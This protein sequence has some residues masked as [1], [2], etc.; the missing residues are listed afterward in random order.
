M[1]IKKVRVGV[2]GA[3]PH[4]GWAPRSHL[5][6]LGDSADCELTAVCT[7]KQESAEESKRTFGARLAFHDY[8][9]MIAHPDIDAV[10]VVLR[11]PSHYEPTMAALEAGKH[12]YTEW[13]LG[14]TTAQARE[15][16]DKARAKGVMNAVGLQA[17]VSP[18][19]MYLKD[20]L[21][22][23]YVG[24]VM[25]CHA[26]LFRPGLYEH[27]MDRLWQLDAE[28]GANTL[29]I[30]AM[31]TMDAMRFV[32]GEFSEIGA[33][34]GIQAKNWLAEKTQNQLTSTSPDNILVHARMMSGA[35][36]SAH[37]AHVPY[38]GSL[39]RMEIYGSKGTVLATGVESPQLDEII[40][41]GAKEG[42]KLSE[43]SVPSR[44][45]YVSDRLSRHQ[46]YNVGQ[47]YHRFA[48]AIRTGQPCQPNFDTAIEL[49]ELID[50]IRKSAST[51]TTVK[52]T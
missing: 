9:Q 37:I 33:R 36:A 22:D 46:P 2:I 8:R 10:S 15:M 24:E 42:D 48:E 29:T 43:L 23:G 21:A 4:R 7:T 50:V 35:V 30:A 47:M 1:A 14:Q 25:A 34:L 18:A 51:G 39:Y 13:P 52:Y 40:L 41:A 31:H 45:Q 32:L 12:V 44:Y 38:A 27:M 26:S 20:L 17:R 16:A 6:A 28:K 5:I 3:N 11:V 49:H 19:L